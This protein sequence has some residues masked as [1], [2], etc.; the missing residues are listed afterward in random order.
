MKQRTRPNPPYTTKTGIQIGIRYQLPPPRMWRDEELIQGALLN[1]KRSKVPKL[2]L[3]LVFVF[4]CYALV[5][6]MVR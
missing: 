6:F 1:I 4:L 5:G 3:V 2:W